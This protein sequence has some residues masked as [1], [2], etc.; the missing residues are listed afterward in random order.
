M[1]QGVGHVRDERAGLGVDLAA[2]EAEAAVDAVQ[3]V[4]EAAVGDGDRAD[5]GLDAGRPR[6]PLEDLAVAAHGVRRVRV[7]VRVAPRP[8]LAGDGQLLLDL[9]VEGAQVGVADRPVGAD[10]VV[11]QHGE[12]ARMEARGVAGVV[13]HRPADTAA[14]VVGAHRDGVAAADLA[15]VG[16]VEGV[17]ATLVGDPVGVGVPERAGVE[18]HD[19][20]AGAGQALG[21]D[22]AARTGAHDDEVD[23][24]A[25]VEAAHVVAQAVVGP[26]AVGRQQP[27]GVVAG[28]QLAL[29]ARAPR[30][31][32]KSS[33]RGPPSSRAACSCRAVSTRWAKGVGRR[34][35]A[36]AT[37]QWSR[38]PTPRST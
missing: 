38:P 24:V 21:Q 12:V 11:A 36:S 5:A 26:G 29:A 22:A 23:L 19:A 18:A 15:R 17:R 14:R 32:G 34:S 30:G 31:D 10:A 4:P 1:R 28:A 25:V 16:P 2:L 37:S 33:H 7:A 9:L 27:G 6:P 3:A 13:H 35:T 20:P 8:V